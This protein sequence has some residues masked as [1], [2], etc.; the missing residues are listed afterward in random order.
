MSNSKEIIRPGNK[1]IFFKKPA[2]NNSGSSQI[3]INES[4]IDAASR[5]I[6]DRQAMNDDVM[7]LVPELKQAENIIVGSIISPNDYSKKELLSDY[8]NYLELPEDVVNDIRGL[9]D[10][11]V[12]RY[13]LVDDLDPSARECLFRSGA[14]PELILPRSKINEII[15]SDASLKLSKKSDLENFKIDDYT[16]KLEKFGYINVSSDKKVKIDNEEFTLKSLNVSSIS[17][18]AVLLTPELYDNARKEIMS[19]DLYLGTQT[20]KDLESI[21]SDV[22][23]TYDNY[24]RR[25]KE[26]YI[27]ITKDTKI[28]N[29]DI[30]F[31]FKLNSRAILPIFTDDPKDHLGYYLIAD[32]MNRP[33][34]RKVDDNE[35]FNLYKNNN[36]SA[37]VL[38]GVLNNASKSL[39]KTKDASIIISNMVDVAGRILMSSIDDAVSKSIYRN[40]YNIDYENS[41]LKILLARALEEKQ[42]KL[43]FVPAEYISYIA[44]DYRKNGTGK[45]LV[46]DITLLASFKAMLLLSQI[47]ASVTTNIPVNDV[48]VDIDE[49]DPEPFKTK[50]MLEQIIMD[51]GRGRL[52]WGETSIE[53]FGNWIQNSGTRITW[54]HK[55]FPDTK[56]TMDKKNK[57]VSYTPDTAIMDTIS[58]YM[59]RHLGLSPSILDEAN[60][61]E[62]ASVAMVNHAL[63]NKINNE[64]QDIMNEG[65]SDKL[66]KLT[67]ADSQ[68]FDSVKKLV[69]NNESKILGAINKD[70][71]D[72]KKIKEL[73]DG[74]IIQIALDIVD[75]MKVRVPRAESKDNDELREKFTKFKE[76]INDILTEYTESSYLNDVVSELGITK[77]NMIGNMK[78]I[79]LVDWCE[80]HN[81]AKGMVKLLDMTDKEDLK[82]LTSR[83]TEK[84]T[85]L[86]SLAV[87]I[88]DMKTKILEKIKPKEEPPVDN[89]GEV[90][91]SGNPIEPVPTDT[92]EETE[93]ETPPE[94]LEQNPDEVPNEETPPTEE[95]ENPEELPE[96]TPKEEEEVVENPEEIK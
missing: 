16:D 33:I 47:Y 93:L 91:E 70:L 35:L 3:N 86:V 26:R 75:G 85:N 36:G 25:T 18:P 72:D 38:K 19:K 62:F 66:R 69:V 89:T 61:A 56:I 15:T 51:G 14:Y 22:L 10:T 41:L 67:K 92:G 20:S 76:T 34:T 64:R 24:K 27:C 87:A 28:N 90:D 23:S 9:I 50:E 31:R 88:A 65:Q 55:T 52:A 11:N 12:I 57:E 21:N 13:K 95:V 68:A 49:K 8:D 78:L 42:T 96:E 60:G 80:E 77:E 29:D 73:S 84:D 63:S 44:F 17:N 30:P 53:K 82:A 37:T 2:N 94:E 6:A 48:V 74:L 79:A 59:L 81:Y 39:D 83:I 4:E 7:V 46:E 45:T 32:E 58:A 40:S 1:D 5:S 71:E 43:I 54:N